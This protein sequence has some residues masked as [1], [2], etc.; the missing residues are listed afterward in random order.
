MSHVPLDEVSEPLSVTHDDVLVQTQGAADLRA[1]L[2]GRERGDRLDGIARKE[3]GKD[4]REERDDHEHDD[5]LNESSDD[6]FH[7]VLSPLLR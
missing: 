4:G 2:V 5:Q 3:S 7:A 1:L 6:R